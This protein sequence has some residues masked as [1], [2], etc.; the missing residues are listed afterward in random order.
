M[1]VRALALG[2]AAL[3]ASACSYTTS[4]KAPAAGE[5]WIEDQRAGEVSPE[6]ERVKV[7]LTLRDPTWQLYLDEDDTPDASGVLPRT[8]LD[9]L[10]TSSL[11][12]CSSL[13][14]P[15]C[16]VV[17]FVCAN[18]AVCVV[19]LAPLGDAFLLSGINALLT[20]ADSASWA[21]VPLV[22]ACALAGFAPLGLLPLALRVP[23]EVE[24]PLA[25]PLPSPSA[26]SREALASPPIESESESVAS[27]EVRY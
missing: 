18:P 14:V 13:S 23:E 16:S 24:L 5:L 9:P 26:P 6:G 21:T 1:S 25:A 20:S 2:L 4:A 17:G 10:T 8:R 27:E 7:P 11:C 22:A 12:A 3:F 15:A 19:C